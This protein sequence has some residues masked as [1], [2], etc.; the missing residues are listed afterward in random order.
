MPEPTLIA[1]I[2]DDESLCAALSGL[3]RSY[4]Y[5]A[6]SFASAETFLA[7]EHAEVCA[8]I[9]TDIHMPGLS[10]IDLKHLLVARQR[11]VPVIMITA[12]IDPGT[13]ARALASGAVCVLRK[14]FKADTLMECVG[15]A[16]GR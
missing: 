6:Q 14:P 13:E 4:G 16:L 8:C 1:V 3:L 7:W 15:K 5:E 9:V 12:R 2:D 11:P 10:G